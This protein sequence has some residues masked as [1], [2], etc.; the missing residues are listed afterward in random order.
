MEQLDLVGYQERSEMPLPSLGEDCAL[1]K[2]NIPV[3]FRLLLTLSDFLICVVMRTVG[4]GT[5]WEIRR[6]RGLSLLRG[7]GLKYT[8]L[9]LQA[10]WNRSPQLVLNQFHGLW[11]FVAPPK[12]WYASVAS[13]E[14]KL[15]SQ[16][17]KVDELARKVGD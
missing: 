4:Y 16:L 8:A 9:F 1:L 10:V 15:C 6:R 2:N 12:Y 17:E 3:F 13:K 5:L 11:A 7:I 14:E